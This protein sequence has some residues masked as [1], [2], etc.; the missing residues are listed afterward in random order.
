MPA[1]ADGGRQVGGLL[2]GAGFSRRFG[3]DKRFHALPD[4]TPMAVATTRKYV[5]VFDPVCVV[6]R[7]DDAQLRE[8][9]GALDASLQFVEAA[10][11]HLGMGHSLAAGTAELDWDY[12]FVG[13]LDMP[14]V[15]VATLAAL[16]EAAARGERII[17]PSHHGRVGHPVGFPRALLPQLR[18]STGDAG[19]RDVLREHAQRVTPVEVDDTG[20]LIDLDR[21]AD[22]PAE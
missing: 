13:L 12:T 14:F 5:Q 20:V 22:A 3:A 2:L 4:G 16:R 17:R 9:L 6:V 19:A 21:P 8:L 11:A 15:A 7:P 18:R 10:D 1:S